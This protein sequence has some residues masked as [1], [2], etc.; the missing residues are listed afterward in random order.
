[1]LS[2]GESPEW[3]RTQMG[4]S[5]LKEISETYG[6]YIEDAGELSGSRINE[7]LDKRANDSSS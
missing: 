1:M 5:S 7:L 6:S 3:V 2:A 4:H